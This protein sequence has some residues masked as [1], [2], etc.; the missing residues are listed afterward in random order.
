MENPV[1]HLENADIYQQDNLVLSKV[2]FTLNKGDFYYLIGKTGS[3]KSSLLKTLYGDLRLQ[4]GLGSIVDFDLKKM[5][6]KDIPFLRRKLGIVFQDFKLLN[7]RNVFSNL[8]FVLKATGW[9]DK[10]EMKDKIHEVLDKVGMKE[11][12]YKKT[13]E[14]S[15]GEQQRVAIARALLNDPELILADEPT[16]NLDP[17]TSLEVMEL[18]NEIHQSGKT[19]LMATHDYQLIVKFKQKVVKCEGG[20]LF[21][22]VQQTV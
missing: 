7:D 4:R 19:I 8:E 11:K 21:E 20:E 3:G 12:Y 22:V 10:A 13:F 16:G 2:N 9:K 14:L 18:L 5:K 15:G 17:K 1:L 6:E